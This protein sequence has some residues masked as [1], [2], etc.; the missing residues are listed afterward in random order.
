VVV[1]GWLEAGVAGLWCSRT[2]P[3]GEKPS[4]V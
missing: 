3:E 1:Y 4:F 2:K